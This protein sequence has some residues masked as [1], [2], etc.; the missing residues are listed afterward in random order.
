M[1][2]KRKQGWVRDRG[3]VR[4]PSAFMARVWAGI[5]VWVR[6]RV[7]ISIVVVFK[8]MQKAVF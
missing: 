2:K 1:S 4:V 8:E 7:G 6:L 5:L 3:S